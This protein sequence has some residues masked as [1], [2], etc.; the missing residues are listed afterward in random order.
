MQ[1]CRVFL[2]VDIKCG[3]SLFVVGGGG[4]PKTGATTGAKIRDLFGI[5]P[6]WPKEKSCI[7]PDHKCSDLKQRAS[8]H[9]RTTGRKPKKVKTV[10][11][12]AILFYV[13]SCCRRRG[14]PR[15]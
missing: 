2:L 15:P 4:V 5:T 1:F 6:D 3:S 9:N 12:I 8:T 14:I 11:R 13:A 7:G 10:S